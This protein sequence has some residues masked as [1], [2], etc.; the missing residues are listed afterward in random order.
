LMPRA[1]SAL[2]SLVESPTGTQRKFAA[3][4]NGWSPSPRA[5]RGVGRGRRA[6]PRRGAGPGHVLAERAPPARR[7]RGLHRPRT[8]SSTP[9]PRGARPKPTRSP[10]SL[11]ALDRVRVTRSWRP[12]EQPDRGLSRTR[13]RPH[14]PAPLGTGHHPIDRRAGTPMPVD[15]SGCRRR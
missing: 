13:R 1:S 4:G 15:C 14:P 12:G 10:V 7:A 2:P 11:N 8:F 3:E 6:P 9:P 5:R